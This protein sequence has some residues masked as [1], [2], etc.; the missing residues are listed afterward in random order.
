MAHRNQFLIKNGMP[1]SLTLNIEPEGAFFALSKGEEVVVTDVFESSPVTIKFS[2]SNEGPI[3]SVWPG[4][5]DVVV[6][7][8]GVDVLDLVQ[9]A[10]KVRS[11]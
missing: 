4:D 3:V 6:E 8:G 7:K 5:G 1:S 2:E 11:A 10:V 9:N